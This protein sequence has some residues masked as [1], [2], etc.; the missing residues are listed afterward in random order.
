MTDGPFTLHDGVTI[1]LHRG[2]AIVSYR[3]LATRHRTSP[4][5]VMRALKR[6][7]EAEYISR[8]P[9][10]W[11]KHGLGKVP[12]IASVKDFDNFSG[13]GDDGIGHAETWDE[14]KGVKKKEDLSPREERI[15]P[16]VSNEHSDNSRTERF[17][18]EDTATADDVL[19]I[20]RHEMR[21]E[22]DEQKAIT[23]IHTALVRN[24]PSQLAAAIGRYAA[25]SPEPISAEHFFGDMVLPAYLRG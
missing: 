13:G 19:R 20:Y 17:H 12:T 22:C 4:A 23:A 3:H 5:T 2:E 6:L 9:P 18:L 21:D 11:L 10:H 25:T 15:S 8:R 14:P 1:T 16:R 24:S 7:Q